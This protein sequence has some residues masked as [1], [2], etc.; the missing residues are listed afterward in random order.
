MDFIEED[1]VLHNFVDASKCRWNTYDRGNYSCYLG[2]LSPEKG[3]RKLIEVINTLRI[4]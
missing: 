3:L 1:N 4:S 2:R